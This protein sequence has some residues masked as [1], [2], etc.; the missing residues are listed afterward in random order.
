LP[1]IDV[2]ETSSVH[3]GGT[4]YRLFFQLSYRKYKLKS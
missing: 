1:V 3:Q 2:K 4:S